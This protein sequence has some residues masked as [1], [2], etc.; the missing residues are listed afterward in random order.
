[1]TR[2]RL[3]TDAGVEPADQE[4]LSSFNIRPVFVGVVHELDRAALDAKPQ[5]DRSRL[6]GKDSPASVA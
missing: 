2:A 6:A 1:M 4:A 3:P 5:A